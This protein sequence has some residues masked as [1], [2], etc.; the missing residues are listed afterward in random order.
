ME[1]K[2]YSTIFLRRSLLCA[3]LAVIVTSASCNQTASE[4]PQVTPPPVHYDVPR[5]RPK[6]RLMQ[7]PSNAIPVPG[8]NATAAETDQYIDRQ[9]ERILGKIDYI[10]REIDGLR[11]GA[12]RS[13]KDPIY[14]YHR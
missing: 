9:V 3:F 6:S 13:D 12:G 1:L 8:P 14:E 4:G 10:N 11:P 7:P 2:A 5:A